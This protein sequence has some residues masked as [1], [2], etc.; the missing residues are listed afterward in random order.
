[1]LRTYPLCVALAATHPFTRLKSVPLQK[2]AAEP[3]VAL[4][5]KDYRE[6]YRNLDRIFVKPRIAVE[7]DAT[8]SL[9]IE[10]EAGHGIALCMPITKLATG[11]RLLYRPITGKTELVS[12]GITRAIKGD[13]TPAGEKFC[14]ILR[15]TSAARPMPER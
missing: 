6:Y 10:V 3:L 2:I 9:I 14:E 5:R 8:S 15:K 11:K 12:I 1:L 7:C 13:L 4:R